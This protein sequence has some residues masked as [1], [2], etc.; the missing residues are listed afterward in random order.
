MS[1]PVNGCPA[2]ITDSGS[3]DVIAAV[4]GKI[5]HVTA[6]TVTNSHASVGTL[7][8]IMSG[9]KEIWQGYAKEGGGGFSVALDPGIPGLAGDAITAQCASTGANVYVAAAGWVN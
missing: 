5:I 4:T 7:V 1:R 9:A 8:S 6:I 3:H 2:A